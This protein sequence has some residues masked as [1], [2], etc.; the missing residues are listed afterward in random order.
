MIEMH[1]HIL[2]GVDSG[3]KDYNDSE[4]ML[5]EAVGQGIKEIIL[6]PHNKI[7]RNTI[8]TRYKT[9]VKWFEKKNI[10]FHL[11]C[12]INYTIDVVE[13]IINNELLTMNGT[14]VV[15]I[16]FGD[17]PFEEILNVLKELKKHDY[18]VIIAHIEYYTQLS[19]KNIEELKD[20]GALIQVNAETLADKK[21]EKWVKQM[22]K[23]RL[24]DFVSSNIHNSK[25][26]NYMSEAYQIVEKKTTEG[27][28][29]LIFRRNQ[30]NFFLL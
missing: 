30:K 21:N 7:D 1:T 15:L 28:A 4:K 18:K 23:E 26:K 10:K 24:I 6:T 20:R 3:C 5:D 11:G 12:E 29:E 25:D 22:L 2:P 16:D 27:Y 14:N 19:M 13:K 9:F 17:S 8:V